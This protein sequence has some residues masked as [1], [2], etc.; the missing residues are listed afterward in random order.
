[1][2]N[3]HANEQDDIEVDQEGNE[4]DILSVRLECV[5]EFFRFPAITGTSEKPYFVDSVDSN[6]RRKKTL[7]GA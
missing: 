1:M 3:D 7:L 5:L 6:F 2:I 4:A